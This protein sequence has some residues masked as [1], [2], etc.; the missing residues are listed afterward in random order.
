MLTPYIE[1]DISK[2]ADKRILKLK[3]ILKNKQTSLT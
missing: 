1:E 2:T 3:Y